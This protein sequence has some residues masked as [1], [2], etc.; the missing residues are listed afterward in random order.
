[1][2][3]RLTPMLIVLICCL[4]LL[5]V[6]QTRAA[7]DPVSE[8][9]RWLEQQIPRTGAPAAAAAVVDRDGLVYSR[10]FGQADEDSLFH[11]ASLSK[12]VT[13]TAVLLLVQD[14]LVELDAP[15]QEYIP[16]FTT[17]DPGHA[18][19]VTVRHLLN[20]TSGLSDAGYTASVDLPLAS[21]EEMTADLASARAFAPPGESFAYFNGNYQVLGHLVEVV[22]GSTFEDFV[23]DQIFQPLGMASSSYTTLPETLKGYNLVFGFPV[24]L[25]DTIRPPSPSGGL[26]TTA[27]DM[28]RLVQMYLD[29]GAPLLNPEIA[30][31]A[32]TPPF[33]PSDGYGMGWYTSSAGD[34]D[35][36]AH[37]GDINSFHADMALLPEAGYG[38]VLLYNTNN[39]IVN[40]SAFPA[41]LNGL[42]LVLSGAEAPSGGIS[43]RAIGLFILAWLLWT[44][45]AGIRKAMK[46]GAW[47]VEARCWKPFRRVLSLV[48]NLLPALVLL[49]LPQIILLIS[50]RT[51]SYSLLFSYIPDVLLV[52]GAAGVLG[53]VQFILR[54][55]ALRT[56]SSL[57]QG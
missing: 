34:V 40:F 25:A 44:L 55:R 16:T 46:A 43:I 3:S 21:L 28:A 9:D 8:V 33:D 11:A 14:G 32:L 1:M 29:D 52:L 24:H 19:A 51:A 47:A 53:I 4:V 26:V 38:A 35:F 20:Q 57:A 18:A 45:Y 36:L 5:P 12:S 50:G 42:A 13:A 22:T 27:E 7:A 2:K 41:A 48:A 31:L 56:H 37:G 15:V 17:A 39:L 49:F 23:Q 54:V 30:S 6:L 10:G